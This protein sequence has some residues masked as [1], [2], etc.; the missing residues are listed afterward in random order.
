MTMSHNYFERPEDPLGFDKLR[1]D[2][3]RER[4]RGLMGAELSHAPLQLFVT[5][6]DQHLPKRL[7]GRSATELLMQTTAAEILEVPGVGPTRLSR[8]LDVIERALLHMETSRESRSALHEPDP[9]TDS[10][11]P[12]AIADLPEATPGAAHSAW[13]RYF[14]LFYQHR[15]D[16]LPIGMFADS[17][18]DLP[19][20]LWDKPLSVFRNP[21]PL[22]PVTRQKVELVVTQL[23]N[24]LE[25][26]D[27]NAF[28]SLP[29]LPVMRQLAAW[30]E[31]ACRQAEP[32]TRVEFV[33]GFCEPFR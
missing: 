15:L 10:S 5:A 32:P 23:A 2:R 17:I 7:L 8:L 13:Q 20:G 1:F 6:D 18:R 11:A 21:E 14:E 3:A 30:V 31:R 27:P 25:S 24:F 29:A 9:I 28:A 19:R 12:I 4:L 16:H 22:G 33:G 26:V